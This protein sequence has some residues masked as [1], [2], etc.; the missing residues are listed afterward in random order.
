MDELFEEDLDHM[1]VIII[2]VIFTHA[3]CGQDIIITLGFFLSTRFTSSP[4][5][6]MPYFSSF[7]LPSCFF[8]ASNEALE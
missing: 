8:I 7:V 2:C 1:V 3:L 4:A 6:N 5:R